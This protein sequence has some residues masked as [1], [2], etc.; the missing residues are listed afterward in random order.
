MARPKKYNSPDEMQEMIDAYFKA[1]DERTKTTWTK[2]G[3]PVVVSH[4]R[5]YTIEGL[6][7]ALDLTRM[8]LLNYSEDEQF[9]YI[10]KKAKER[11][12]SQVVENGLCGDGNSTFSIFYTKCNFEFNDG[13][14][15]PKEI[16][17]TINEK[18]V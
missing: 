14:Q 12:L 17:I 18:K 13:N 3:E 15:S 5:P 1:C 10:I 7:V 2:D 4:P 11:V 16:E 6:A 8:S 9:F